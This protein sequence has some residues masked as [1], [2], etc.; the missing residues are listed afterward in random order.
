MTVLS[1]QGN[2]VM[3]Y[4]VA[5]LLERLFGTDTIDDIEG[6]RAD[7][8]ISDIIDG[9]TSHGE[10]REVQE[11]DEEDAEL[12]DELVDDYLE[13]DDEEYENEEDEYVA[14]QPTAPV[15]P[16]PN[17]TFTQPPSALPTTSSAFP[18][19]PKPAV[20]A[21]AFAG[22]VSSPNV[23]GTQSAFGTSVFPPVTANPS[24]STFGA[25]NTAPK[26]S[27]FGPGMVPPPMVAP[28]P[29]QALSQPPSSSFVQLSE[30]PTDSS[31]KPAAPSSS[32][33]NIFGM[34]FN[35][36]CASFFSYSFQAR[37]RQLHTPLRL[38]P[39]VMDLC[40]RRLD[41]PQ[42]RLPTKILTIQPQG[43]LRSP[44]PGHH[45]RHL[46]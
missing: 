6:I 8:S 37:R 32:P 3:V 23:F 34:F 35:L 1:E 31:F 9:A 5:C 16:K 25:P 26:Q 28:S 46:L 27:V 17:P 13:A 18:T 41:C 43:H 40:P 20:A 19:L 21:G 7:L 29:N 36:V 10:F 12:D 44:L 14:P 15:L 33:S 11:V 30:R 4:L 45:H 22:L 42:R 38:C 39:W 24:P 2:R